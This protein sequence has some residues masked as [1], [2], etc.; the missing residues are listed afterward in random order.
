MLEVYF[1]NHRKILQITLNDLIPDVDIVLNI[2]HLNK[3][4][5]R[6][7]QNEVGTRVSSISTSILH[8]TS[9]IWWRS[10]YYVLF[11]SYIMF[12]A[13]SQSIWRSFLIL[14]RNKHITSS[15]TYQRT[16]DTRPMMLYILW[17]IQ[18][19][20][21]FDGPK[22]LA[23]TDL[24]ILQSLG[25]YQNSSLQSQLI[26]PMEYED[27]CLPSPCGPDSNPPR[28]IRGIHHCTCLPDMR[29]S[30]YIRMHGPCPKLC[31]VNA[32][33]KTTSLFV[34]SKTHWRSIL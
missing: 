6:H 16:T 12:S 18:N 3:I 10:I 1:I 34:Y 19:H 8:T 24:K 17:W 7:E 31:G 28:I 9:G 29:L 5:S 13:E 27:P 11:F 22:I 21:N 30:S 23:M 20:G 33:P 4:E 15:S 2:Y 26:E 32:V 25:I 14:H